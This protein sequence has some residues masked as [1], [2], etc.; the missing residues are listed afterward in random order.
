MVL[1]LQTQQKIDQM[2]TS[3]HFSDFDVHYTKVVKINYGIHKQYILRRSSPSG[4][5]DS[6]YLRY[7]KQTDS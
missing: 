3:H 4:G 2:V 5:V 6:G 1:L 7:Q